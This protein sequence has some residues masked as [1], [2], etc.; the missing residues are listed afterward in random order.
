MLSMS[1]E[2]LAQLPD[3]INSYI[4]L[5]I[6][7]FFPSISLEVGLLLADVLAHLDI[8]L[9]I[10][11]LSLLVLRAETTLQLILKQLKHIRIF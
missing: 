3:K 7:S 2:R 10:V 11:P 4:K 8:A 1:G 9:H 6:L 5:F